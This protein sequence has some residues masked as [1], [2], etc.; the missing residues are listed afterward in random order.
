[1]TRGRHPEK[2]IERAAEIAEKRGLVRYYEHGPGCI[3]DFSIVRP[4]RLDEV[5]VKRMRHIRCTAKWLERDAADEI[6][7][8]KMYPAS[9]QISRE[10]W[11]VSPEYALRFFRVGDTG[12][13]ELGEGGEPLPPGSPVHAALPA[14]VRY[15]RRRR[16]GH[17]PEKGSEKAR[18]AGSAKQ[19]ARGSPPESEPSGSTSS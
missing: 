16:K 13:I 10:I 12:L 1:M 15:L 14:P 18:G 3:C 2:A 6:A 19:P 11:I 17:V 5:R 9:P 7:G 4:A 8:L